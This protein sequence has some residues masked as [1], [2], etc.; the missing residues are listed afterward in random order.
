MLQYSPKSPPGAGTTRKTHAKATP[1]KGRGTPSAWRWRHQR[2]VSTARLCRAT[3]MASASINGLTVNIVDLVRIRFQHVD[4]TDPDQGVCIPI[5]VYG[6]S[7]QNAHKQMPSDCNQYRPKKRARTSEPYSRHPFST[8]RKLQYICCSTCF[9]QKTHES[10]Y[11]KNLTGV[12]PKTPAGL[13]HSTRCEE[14]HCKALRM[15]PSTAL[16]CVIPAATL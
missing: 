1:R 15:R 13:R 5:T 3:K 16:G 10:G 14:A 6:L 4:R 12:R 9:D 8:P 11:P 7:S 2:P